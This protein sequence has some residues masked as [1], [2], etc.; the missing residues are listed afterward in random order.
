MGSGHRKFT[1]TTVTWGLL[2]SSFYQRGGRAESELVSHQE[3]SM[4][5]ALGCGGRRGGAPN[6]CG[7]LGGLPSGLHLGWTPDAEMLFC[8][9]GTSGPADDTPHTET[10]GAE[11]SP[12]DL[13]KRRKEQQQGLGCP[14]CRDGWGELGPQVFG[15]GRSTTGVRGLLWSWG[16]R[17]V[18]WPQRMDRQLLFPTCLLAWRTQSVRADGCLMVPLVP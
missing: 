14:A 1:R 17:G 8:G 15:P 5:S 9:V 3:P 2:L 10:L 6:D 11:R 7:P 13:G 4:W 18:C 16:C 12:A